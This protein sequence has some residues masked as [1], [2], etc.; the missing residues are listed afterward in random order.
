MLLQLSERQHRTVSDSATPFK[1]TGSSS[2]SRSGS[3]S[4]SQTRSRS[5]L[6]WSVRRR[7]LYSAMT[8]E[9]RGLFN[10]LQDEMNELKGLLTVSDV[11]AKSKVH[12]C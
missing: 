4:S 1:E 10:A 8:E 3:R 6:Q 11:A 12:L 9:E 2:G 7:Q 5:S